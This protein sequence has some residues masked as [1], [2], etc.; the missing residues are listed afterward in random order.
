M[1]TQGCV[2]GSCIAPD[3]CK[4]DFGYVGANCSIQCQCN[5]HSECAGPDRLDT[6]LQCHNFTQGAQCQR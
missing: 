5:G 3:H 2:R 4:C 1:C 6:C